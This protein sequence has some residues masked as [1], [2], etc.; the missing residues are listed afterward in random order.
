MGRIFWGQGEGKGS[1]S[2]TIRGKKPIEMQAPATGAHPLASSACALVLLE[3]LRP[4][5][6]PKRPSGFALA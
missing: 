1:P 4:S 5:N 2:P 6:L 3:C